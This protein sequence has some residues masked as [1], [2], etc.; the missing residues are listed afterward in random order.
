MD[1]R[2]VTLSE[3]SHLEAVMTWFVMIFLIRGYPIII[4]SVGTR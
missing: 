2:S 3:I 1:E 4:L